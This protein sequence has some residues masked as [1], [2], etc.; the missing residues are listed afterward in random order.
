MLTRNLKNKL[1]FI[2]IDI[3]T[4]FEYFSQVHFQNA[5]TFILWLIDSTQINILESILGVCYID[6]RNQ[7]YFKR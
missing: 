3:T 5:F 4:N 7:P 1:D 6:T 2:H